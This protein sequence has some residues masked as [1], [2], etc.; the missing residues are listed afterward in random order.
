M[1]SLAMRAVYSSPADAPG[2][3]SRGTGRGVDAT[4]VT[5]VIPSGHGAANGRHARTGER[6][7]T[8]VDDRY[9]QSAGDAKKDADEVRRA[10]QIAMD[11]RDNGG[12]GRP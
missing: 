3:R 2:R 6:N 4:H 11:R 7:D 9:T 10:V 8:V 12:R 5:E 1:D